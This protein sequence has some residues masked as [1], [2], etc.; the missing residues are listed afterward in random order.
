MTEIPIDVSKINDIT[1]K[2]VDEPSLMEIVLVASTLLAVGIALLGVFLTNR[3]TKKSIGLTELELE[4][5]MRP[6][7]S[8]GRPVPR[9]MSVEFP[10]GTGRN[11]EWEEF[12]DDID[13]LKPLAK[14]VKVE[15]LIKNTGIIPAK[16]IFLKSIFE[17]GLV[18]QNMVKNKDPQSSSK[19]MPNGE[20][21][22]LFK[23]SAREWA[24]KIDHPLYLGFEIQHEHNKEKEVEGKIWKLSF[25]L[26]S[27]TESW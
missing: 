12:M 6:W 18:T 24:D 8:I 20:A 26:Y 17:V 15:I 11:Y 22:Y 21:T 4:S 2:M 9:T 3:S 25:G 10:N 27:E 16:N 13:N 7:L 14:E 1:I 5:R 23:I 19:I